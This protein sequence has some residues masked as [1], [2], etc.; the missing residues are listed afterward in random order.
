MNNAFNAAQG[1]QGAGQQAFGMG[2]DIQEPINAGAMQQDAMQ[3]LIAG[4]TQYAGYAGQ[5]Q[6]GLNTMMSGLTGMPN[7]GG[8]TNYQTGLLNY[9]QAAASF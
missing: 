1:L 8:S 6:A 4:K 3:R 2:Q 9:L 7:M 5:P